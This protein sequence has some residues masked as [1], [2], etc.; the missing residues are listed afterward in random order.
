MI[1]FLLLNYQCFPFLRVCFFLSHITVSKQN[2]DMLV[3]VLLSQIQLK[4]GKPPETP[5][6]L[7][8]SPLTY[9]NFQQCPY[10]FSIISG[11]ILLYNYQPLTTM[12]WI[13]SQASPYAIC[14]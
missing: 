9:D 3:H 6:Y 8:Y 14:G 5:N 4:H 12:A 10:P 1:T 7:P 11:K 13:L 2:N